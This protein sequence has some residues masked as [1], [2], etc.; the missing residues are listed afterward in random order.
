MPNK[1][2]ARQKEV[3]MGSVAEIKK[4]V[5]FENM[6]LRSNVNQTTLAGT[7]LPKRV[8][9]FKFRLKIPEG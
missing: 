5:N 2:K 8:H 3:S 6:R 7:V 1:T 9:I 4:T